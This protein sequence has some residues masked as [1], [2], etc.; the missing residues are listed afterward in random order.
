MLGCVL[1]ELT[2]LRVASR[3]HTAQVLR[4]A[5]AVYKLDT[6]D[7]ALKVKQEFAARDRKQTM[8][9]DAAKAL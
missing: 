6:D 9:E 4:E 2:I 7:I 5:A 8:K 1:I 3:H